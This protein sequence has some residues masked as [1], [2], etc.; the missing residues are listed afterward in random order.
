MPAPELYTY[1]VA[2]VTD[3]NTALLALLDIDASAA[4]IK[5]YSETDVLLSTVVLQ[6]PSGTID[7]ATGV[8][9]LV[10]AGPDVSAAASGVCTWGTI[11]DGAGVVHLS[12]PAQAGATPVSGA[13][14]LN[15]V[16]IV[17][18]SQ[19]TVVSAVIG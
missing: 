2:A 11:T 9:T 18:T 5:L 10:A 7:V 14:V 17:A 16:E 15:S 13:L 6:D 12:L 3:A 1:S 8:L 4:Q 19:V